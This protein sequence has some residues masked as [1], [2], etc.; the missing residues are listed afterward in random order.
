M[1]TDPDRYI[2][3]F[4]DGRR[5]DDLRARRGAAAPASHRA[6]DQGAR[7]QGRRRA[8][9]VDAGRRARAR[10]P[11][12]S[13]SCWSCRST[14]ASAARAFIPRSESK[15]REVRALLDAPAT[16]APIEIDGGIDLHNVAARRG[17]RRADP[18]R[19]LGDLRHRRSRARDAR[20]QG[21]GARAR[22]SGVGPVSTPPVHLPRP[23]ALRRDRPDG[24]RLL[25]ELLRLVRGRPDGPAARSP[26]GA[27]ARW[28]PTG[29]ALPVDRSALRVPAVGA[30]RRR[31]RDR[32]DRRAGVAGAGEVRPTRSCAPPTARRWR[33][34][35]TVHA[36]LDRAAAVRCRLAATR[37]RGRAASHEGARHRRRRLHRIDA[38]RAA[39]RRRRRRRRDRL[40]HRL[41][42][43][44]I[45]ERNLRRCWRIRASGSSS[46]RFRTPICARCSPTARMSSTSPRRPASERAGDAI[47]AS[48]P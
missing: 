22:V 27:I 20:A 16:R 33:P 47:S 18:R 37:G 10:S 6:R 25:R 41:L 15:V 1:I 44:A 14:P 19:R 2:E 45:K 29:F 48:I 5:G 7:R 28:K 35:H 36:A 43:A 17:R 13:T 4:A 31:A 38:R 21:R 9:P 46:R 23:R 30:V 32:D 34:A 26:A 12:T 3:A 40:L 11:A 42:P 39:A 24:R 8:Q